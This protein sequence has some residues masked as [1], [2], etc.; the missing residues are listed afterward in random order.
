LLG[1]KDRHNGN[2][3]FDQSGHLLHIDFGFILG[4]APGGG[5]SL[6]TISAFTTG[7]TYCIPRLIVSAGQVAYFDNLDMRA[8][9]IGNDNRNYDYPTRALPY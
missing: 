2:I 1:V 3:L 7:N 8:V 9:Q 4:I 6:L 5:W